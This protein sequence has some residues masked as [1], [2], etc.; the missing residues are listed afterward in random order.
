MQKLT[1]ATI[2]P[3]DGTNSATESGTAVEDESS[4]AA[5]AEAEAEIAAAMA[6]VAPLPVVLPAAEDIVEGGKSEEATADPADQVTQMSAGEKVGGA[7]PSEESAGAQVSAP[8]EREDG[9][10][11]LKS[12]YIVAL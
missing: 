8:G 9:P 1:L 6:A 12:Q 7:A 2:V 4:S 10:R 5:D 11:V 3:G